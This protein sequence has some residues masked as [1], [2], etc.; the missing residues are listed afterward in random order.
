VW[1][2]S[3][4]SKISKALFFGVLAP[5]ALVSVGVLA[6]IAMGSQQPKQAPKDGKDRAA[7]L[8]KLPIVSVEPVKS[9]EGIESLDVSLMGTVVPYRQITLAAEVAGRVKNKSEDC[10]IGRYVHKGDLI[11][12]L[13]A[14]DFELEVRSV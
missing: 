14:T 13:D 5:L 3:S 10:R 12:E 6:F 7:K 1:I 8:L 11:F 2:L 4:T 9:Y